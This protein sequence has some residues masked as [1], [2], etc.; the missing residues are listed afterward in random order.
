VVVVV[1]VN[2]MDHKRPLLQQETE[3]ENQPRES[4]LALSKVT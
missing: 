3:E 2:D 4:Q 1:V